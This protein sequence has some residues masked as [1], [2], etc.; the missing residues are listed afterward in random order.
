MVV[1][2]TKEFM[3]RRSWWKYYRISTP[4][5]KFNP[6]LFIWHERQSIEDELIQLRL[7]K[8][9][10]MT[11]YCYKM[12]EQLQICCSIDWWLRPSAILKT[13]L[14]LKNRF[15]VI[16]VIVADCKK[17]RNMNFLKLIFLTSVLQSEF[18]LW[19]WKKE[20]C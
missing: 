15:E 4:F 13:T 19:I 5:N 6:I 10:H 2:V 16:S 9:M 17:K 14:E 18:M 12:V 7:T 3:S 20:A 1:A 11:S 8:V